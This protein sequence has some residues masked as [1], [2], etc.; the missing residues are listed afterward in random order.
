MQLQGHIWTQRLTRITEH[1]SG[2]KL[3]ARRQGITGAKR[4]PV[5]FPGPIEYVKLSGTIT[6]YCLFVSDQKFSEQLQ[7][8]KNL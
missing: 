2:F 4:Q 6:P 3:K 7:C 8:L 1:H 5:D